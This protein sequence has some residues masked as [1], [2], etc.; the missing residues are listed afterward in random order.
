MFY[1]LIG[2]WGG[3]YFGRIS[4]FLGKGVL[5]IQWVMGKCGATLRWGLHADRAFKMG[6]DYANIS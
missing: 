6:Q 5:K 4:R 1:I 3:A 2:D